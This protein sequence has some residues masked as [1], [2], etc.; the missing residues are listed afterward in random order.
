MPPK[1]RTIVKTKTLW[2]N[3]AKPS[4]RKKSIKDLTA[5][6]LVKSLKTERE[7]SMLISVTPVSYSKKTKRKLE[8]R[9]TRRW[10][11][12][13]PN[14]KRMKELLQESLRKKISRVGIALSKVEDLV[15]RLAVHAKESVVLDQAPE[16]QRYQ[17]QLKLQLIKR[18]N[19]HLI[20]IK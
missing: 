10:K 14:R 1:I 4:A 15:Q 12:K 11:K 17:S 5:S 16:S 13:S 18:I 2:K 20:K 19:L 3:G 6:S 9:S 7:S 8:T